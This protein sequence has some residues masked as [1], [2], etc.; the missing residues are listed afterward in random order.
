MT[1][2]P[3]VTVHDSALVES[4]SIGSGTTIWAFV[5]VLAGASIGAN[6]KIGD[7][8]FIEGGAVIGDRVT[9]K[10]NSLIWHGVTIGDDVFIGPNVV[11]TNDLMPRAHQRSGP[12]DWLT[13][14]VDRGATIGANSTVV[15]GVT[16][17]QH[18]MIGAGTVVSRDIAP[19][20]LVIGNPGRQVGFVCICGSKLPDDYRCVRCGRVYQMESNSLL[21]MSQ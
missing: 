21:E 1:A 20:S 4:D 16:I 15:C 14:T 10:N 2:D 6:C 13:T 8:T 18:A 19:F 3:S 9:I 11:F 5:H 12:E 17:G 7:H